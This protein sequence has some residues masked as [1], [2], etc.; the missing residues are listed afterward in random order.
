MPLTAKDK[1]GSDIDST[2]CSDE[3]WASIHKVKPKAEIYCRACNSLMQPKNSNKG[4]RFFRHYVADEH[5]PSN[6]ETPAHLDL[7]KRIAIIIRSSG[8]RAFLESTPSQGDHG[9]WR[10]DVLAVTEDNRRIAFE[11][12]LAGMTLDEGIRRTEQ[13]AR[14][15][16]SVLWVTTRKVHWNYGIPGVRVVIDGERLLVQHGLAMFRHRSS[17]FRSD[18]EDASNNAE[19][20][21]HA[22]LVPERIDSDF[23][24][25]WQL[26]F[27]WHGTEQRLDLQLV[28]AG[29]L[30]ESILSTEVDSFMRNPD[31]IRDPITRA[32]VV[33]SKAHLEESERRQ[34][35]F[36]ERRKVARLQEEKERVEREAE[37]RREEAAAERWRKN[38]QELLDRQTR[39]LEKALLEIS[40]NTSSDYEL[41]IGAPAEKWNPEALAYT[42]W[43]PGTEKTGHGI[44]IWRG[45]KNGERSLVGI[46]CPVA[47][48]LSPGLGYS[49]SKRRVV[50]YVETDYEAS[51]VSKSLGWKPTF[52]K[53]MAKEI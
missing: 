48:R 10:A 38:T 50:V 24:N 32:V 27:C 46:V 36:E 21:L 53:V 28:V 8:G 41:W 16:I 9:G 33:V 47:S 31:S 22:F 45:P 51:W 52:L 14:D 26:P 44:P 29:F 15:G 1:L 23:F 7:K 4:L 6:G 20:F 42:W 12:Q 30:D 37:Y 34:S 18:S 35:E 11:V 49:W 2:Q 5:C 13:Y 43:A 3:L 25:H 39:V 40:K 17:V 19:K